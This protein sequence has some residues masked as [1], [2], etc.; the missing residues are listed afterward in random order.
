MLW[1]TLIPNLKSDLLHYVTV[2]DIQ[3]AKLLKFLKNVK[4]SECDYGKRV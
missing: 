2:N 3:R 4:F 1:T